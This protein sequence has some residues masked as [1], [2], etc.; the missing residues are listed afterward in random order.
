MAPWA[1]RLACGQVRCSHWEREARERSEPVRPPSALR[2]S[3]QYAPDT[4][5]SLTNQNADSSF[6]GS[7]AVGTPAISYNVILDTGSSCV[8]IF[9]E[10]SLSVLTLLQ[11][12][13]SRC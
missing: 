9:P 8:P 12:F 6:Y 1:A 4:L 13:V 3:S 10:L 11:R 2:S 7:I 5:R